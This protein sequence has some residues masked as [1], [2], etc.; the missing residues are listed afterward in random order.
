MTT[1]ARS[2]DTESH[3]RRRDS[4]IFRGGV[5]TGASRIKL[6]EA[7]QP[8]EWAPQ[9][10]NARVHE[11]TS[12]THIR[13][14]GDGSYTWRPRGSSE[15]E[16]S[17]RAHR[18]SRVS[19]RAPAM[20][21]CTCKGVVAGRVL[22][23]SPQRI[24]IEGSLTYARDPR[25]VPDSGDYLGLVSNKY[26][27]VASPGVTGPGDLEIDAAIFAGR[28]FLVR[29]IDHR[30]RRDAAHLRQPLGRIAVRDR[31]ALRHQD[32]VRHPLRAPAPAGLPVHQSLRSRGLGRAM[33]RGR[34]IST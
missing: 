29:N 14:L 23:Y 9:D 31:A 21:L 22:V 11:F 7:L 3:G 2:F 30:T 28:R 25:D 34:G 4:D 27:E 16:H 8:F 10:E 32:R 24:V 20:R 17:Q 6:P 33:G 26:V 12:D 15:P 5:E 1:A 19:H 18:A 13:F